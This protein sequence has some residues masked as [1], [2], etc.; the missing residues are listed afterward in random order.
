[1]LDLYLVTDDKLAS[2]RDFLK[3]IEAALEG[4]VSMVQLREKELP[5]RP[6]IERARALKALLEPRRVPLIINDRV[7]VALA[8]GADGIH[9]GQQD[10]PFEHAK[11]L[12]PEQAIIGLSVESMEDARYAER[13]EVDYLGVSPLFLTP[14][15]TELQKSWGL[16]GLRRLRQ[17]S[18]HRLVAIG[19]VNAANAAPAIRAGADGL[20]VVSAIMNAEDPRQ[21]AAD[22]RRAIREAKTKKL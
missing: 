2:G 10:M 19:G 5:T 18:R 22:I 12:L 14:T 8:V 15:K 7:D 16:E 11:R 9:I 13:L 17:E 4:G 6:F 3:V 20:A 21:A 1:M